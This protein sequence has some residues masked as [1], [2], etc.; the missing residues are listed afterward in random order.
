MLSLV[1]LAIARS[2]LSCC[3]NKQL[4]FPLLCVYTP[5]RD[6]F[7]E[8]ASKLAPPALSSPPSHVDRFPGLTI[9][10]FIHVHFRLVLLP[11]LL[12]QLLQ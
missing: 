2:F 7:I 5:G 3:Y 1:S 9:S 6:A 4:G 12:H 10:L 8:I 11:A